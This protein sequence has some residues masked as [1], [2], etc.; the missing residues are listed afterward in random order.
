M[1]NIITYL[2]CIVSHNNPN[3]Y[4]KQKEQTYWKTLHHLELYKRES[5]Y[6]TIYNSNDRGYMLLLFII[7]NTKFYTYNFR[8]ADCFVIASNKGKYDF[9][10][11]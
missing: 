5:N 7:K 11:N 2:L 8:F 10:G 1:N 3:G 6:M 4:G 9:D